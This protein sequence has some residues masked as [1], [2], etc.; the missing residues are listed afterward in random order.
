V[1]NPEFNHGVDAA[2]HRLQMPLVRDLIPHDDAAEANPDEGD[3]H[4]RPPRIVREHLVDGLLVNYVF[5]TPPALKS[6]IRRHRIP[7]IWINRKREANCVRPN[8][9]GAAGTATEYLLGHGH[10]RVVMLNQGLAIDDPDTG[11]K[12]YSVVD[13][14]TG[15]D[16]VMRQAGLTPRVID[17]PTLRHEEFL[18]GYLVYRCV[19]WLQ[20]MAGDPDRP[21]AVLCGNG[22]GRALVAACW[23]LGLRVPDDL[24][25]ITFDS[26]A[27]ARHEIVVDR[28]LLPFR[29]IGVRAVEELDALITRPDEPRPPVVLPLEFHRTG[30][31]AR[32]TS[33]S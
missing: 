23:K 6:A 32:P 4:T 19:A 1:H 22:Q 28:V 7:S 5:R 18:P 31:V 11:A 30:S 8:D 9:E 20:Q 21:T 24:S 17:L 16:A 15:Y 33:A 3:G 14:R 12:H 10:Q 13:R 29:Q 25:I 26:M 27:S 2:L